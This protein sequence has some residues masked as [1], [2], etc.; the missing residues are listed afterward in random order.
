MLDE[1]IAR[2]ILLG[3][4]RSGASDDKVKDPAGA[5]SGEGIRSIY[6]DHEMYSHKVTL[7]SNIQASD[8]I[9]EIV[10]SRTA[11][12]GSGNPTLYVADSVLTDWLLLE[13]RIG[14][15]LYDTEASLAAAL[16]VSEI[17][18]VEVME[19][20]PQII[21]I[22]VN[23]T[24][25][26]LGADKGGEVNFFDDFDIDFNQQKYLIETRASGGLTKPKSAL[27]ILR[28][29]GTSA[30]PTA[31]SFNGGTNVITIPSITGITYFIDGEPVSSGA[32]DPITEITEIIAHANS[33][34][35]IPSGTPTN[36]VYTPSDLG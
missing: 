32:Q 1:E 21:G 36:W 17:V 15:R 25:Y 31:P 33:G 13:D 10:R 35:Y 29:L 12:R 27:V 22:I 16:R 2:A 24:D 8:Q 30:T 6:L 9:K 11:Y 34:Y 7:P 26:T 18:S 5:N 4:G 28:T 19:E 20:Y 14:R 3:D 23:L